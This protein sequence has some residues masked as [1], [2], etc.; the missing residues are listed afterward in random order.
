MLNLIWLLLLASGILVAAFNGNIEVVT[1]AAWVT[2]E[3]L[4]SVLI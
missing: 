3:R 2:K 4:K 1:E